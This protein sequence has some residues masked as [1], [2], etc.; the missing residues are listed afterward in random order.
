MAWLVYEREN[1]V[2]D[3]A[4]LINFI[5]S[6]SR[7]QPERSGK[8]ITQTILGYFSTIKDESPDYNLRLQSPHKLIKI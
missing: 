7:T 1:C 3:L 4:R 5:A 8:C 6:L 2:G